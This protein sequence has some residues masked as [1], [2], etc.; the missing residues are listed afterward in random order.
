MVTYKH[1]PVLLIK[2]KHYPV[3]GWV[4]FFKCRSRQSRSCTVWHG[5][6]YHIHN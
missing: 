4:S 5:S 2:F 3:V 1:L 6:P